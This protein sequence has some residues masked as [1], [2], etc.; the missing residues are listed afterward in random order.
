M[1]ALAY[2]LVYMYVDKEIKRKKKKR[3]S[4]L[5]AIEVRPRARAQD[6]GCWLF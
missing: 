1:K 3:A 5:P 4:E 2:H 6:E